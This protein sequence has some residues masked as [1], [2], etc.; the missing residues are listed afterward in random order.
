MTT[1]GQNLTATL[2]RYF[3]LGT[4]SRRYRKGQDLHTEMIE[5]IEIAAQ[6][7]G[8]YTERTENALHAGFGAALSYRKHVQGYRIDGTL[9]H[10]ISTMTPWQFAGSS[11]RWSMPT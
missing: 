6:Y 8:A 11:A 7:P 5:A 10:R 4:R 2:R 3:S 9:A 1:T